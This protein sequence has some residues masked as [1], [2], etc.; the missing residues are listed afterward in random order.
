MK[1]KSSKKIVK[2]GSELESLLKKVLRVSQLTLRE[3]IKKK[4]IIGGRMASIAQL[5][6]YRICQG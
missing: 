4:N 3:K 2:E 6:K 1:T 5:H